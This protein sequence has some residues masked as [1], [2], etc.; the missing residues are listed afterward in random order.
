MV[1]I[2]GTSIMVWVVGQGVG[3][4]GCPR[5]MKKAD[6]VVTKGQDVAGKVAVDFLGAAIVLKVLVVGEDI[7]DKLGA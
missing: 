2:V 6:V 3:A 7:Y 1:V 4:I 5:F